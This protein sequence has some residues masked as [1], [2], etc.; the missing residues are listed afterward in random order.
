MVN[1]KNNVLAYPI[2]TDIMQLRATFNH[3]LRKHNLEFV[4]EYVLE[5]N[6]GAKNTYHNNDHMMYVAIKS[7][8]LFLLETKEGMGDTHMPI[9]ALLVAGMLHDINHSGGEE[10]DDV[11]IERALAVLD[12]MA[13]TLDEKHYTGF[14]AD[15]ESIIQVTQY[16]FVLDPDTLEEKCIRDADI[17][18]STTPNAVGV[19]MEGLRSEM[20][21]KLGRLY[22]RREFVEGQA[23]F[24]ASVQMF[25]N[26]GRAQFEA[27]SPL[28]LEAMQQYAQLM[29]PIGEDA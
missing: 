5:N 4:W 28:A 8:E 15:V 18:Y 16:P 29:E 12:S 20:V 7:V 10:E 13:G 22:S 2:L 26:I 11:N 1:S 23:K 27:C 17:L 3:L 14:S 25:T 6:I 24:I 9:P 19:I 21:A